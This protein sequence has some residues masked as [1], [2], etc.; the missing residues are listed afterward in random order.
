M[1]SKIFTRINSLFREGAY[2]LCFLTFLLCYKRMVVSLTRCKGRFVKCGATSRA[3][4]QQDIFRQRSKWCL[5]SGLACSKPVVSCTVITLK[6]WRSGSHRK[7]EANNIFG[8]YYW[9]DLASYVF[10]LATAT[11]VA[12]PLPNLGDADCVTTDCLIFRP[13]KSLLCMLL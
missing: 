2:T 8:D 9:R 1:Y 6:Q 11:A 5:W 7:R 3:L 12:A 4:I 13:W 10:N